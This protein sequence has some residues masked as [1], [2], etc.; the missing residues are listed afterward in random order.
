MSFQGV[1]LCITDHRIF[2]KA[3]GITDHRGVRQSLGSDSDHP[4]VDVLDPGTADLPPHQPVTECLIAC[5]Q[6]VW[7][8]REFKCDGCDDVP[9]A[10]LPSFKDAV[11]V[12]S[13][14]RRVGTE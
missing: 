1:K 11:T 10:V 4:L 13:E 12:S 5:L 7:W 2:K 8:L 3:S 9:A 6:L 14:E